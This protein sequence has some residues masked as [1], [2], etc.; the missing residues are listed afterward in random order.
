MSSDL[1]GVS[2]AGSVTPRSIDRLWRSPQVGL[3]ILCQ[4]IVV[5]L[6]FDSY[7]SMV[8]IWLRSE[9]Y[10]HGILVFPI[11]AYL[12]WR[13]WPYLRT[14]SSRPSFA[15]LAGLL[16]LS[17]IWWVCTAI[18]I[19][20]GQHFAI[21]AMT[22]VLVVAIAGINFA[23]AIAFPLAYLLFAVP[24]GE[25]FIPQ[26]IDFTAFFTVE[27]LQLCGFPV[28]RDGVY[29]SIPAGDF[30]VAKAC[31]GIR[32]LLASLALGTLYA[33]LS[34]NS[35]W[36]RTAFV[37]FALC[38][39]I[40]ANG[41]RAF[42]IVLLAH[43]SEMRLAVGVDHLIYGWIF[44]GLIMVLMFWVG[45][46]FRD[47][48]IAER[49]NDDLRKA[50]QPTQSTSLRFSVLASALTV[51]AV[52]VGP[53]MATMANEAEA[54]AAPGMPQSIAAWQAA[55]MSPLDWKPAFRGASFEVARNYYSPQ[56]EIAA[57]IIR[58]DFAG[59]N[60]ELASSSNR[61]ADVTQWELG[62]EVTVPVTV[63]DGLTFAVRESAIRS[64]G[65]SRL[66]WRWSEV[67]GHHVNGKVSIKWREFLALISGRR[68]VSVAYLLS[69]RIDDANVEE[70][71]EKLQEF[72][73][74][75][76]NSLYRC[77]H[78]GDSPGCIGA[79]AVRGVR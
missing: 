11:C 20:V 38:L 19:Q 33:Y 32:Y 48:S 25:L 29:F 60:T 49:N 17:V 62:A 7:A 10:H 63:A 26:L 69:T 71:R 66:V 21:V 37:L 56:S 3:L 53:A 4:A 70:A 13:R 8:G 12:I 39:P 18:G 61:V 77:A 9:T 45:E 76:R 44:F 5:A 50:T 16:V 74:V 35:V 57:A 67:D 36:K 55:E 22:P 68:S 78:A 75:A 64:T 14:V 27:A 73:V 28:L 30:E 24:F 41:F 34:Y 59:Q 52:G 51:I 15:G 58:Y 42:G 46:R 6:Y 1:H 40:V 23:R 43:Y 72:L 31:S 65:V 54:P 47:R 79:E 2:S